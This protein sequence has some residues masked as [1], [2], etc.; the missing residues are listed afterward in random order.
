MKVLLFT[1][2]DSLGP[3]SRIRCLQ[4]ISRLDEHEVKVDAHCL[5]NNKMLLRKFQGDKKYRFGSLLFSYMRRLNQVRRAHLYDVVWIQKEFLPG[6]PFWLEH[7]FL[8]RA[9][10]IALDI[11]DA[12]YLKY[13]KNSNPIKRALYSDKFPKIA[14]NYNLVVV[15]NSFLK[16][17]FTRWS[18]NSLLKVIPSVVDFQKYENNRIYQSRPDNL[19]VIGWIGSPSSEKYLRVIISVVKELAYTSNS[20]VE[21]RLIGASPNQ[22]REHDFITVIPWKECTEIKELSHFDVGIMPL[23]NSEWEEG[24]CSFKV[25]QYMA[26]GKPVVLNSTAANR[27]VIIDG[28]NGLFADSHIAWLN[29][30]KKLMDNPSLRHKMGLANMKRAKR[31]YSLSSQSGVIAELFKSV[32]KGR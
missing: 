18:E 29:S 17:K 15:G 19:F 20:R 32:A 5:I 24:K 7:L 21:L 1:K 31:Y 6:L 12:E 13:Q 14:Q 16:S 30:L 27:E 4:Y 10:K 2:Y 8:K 11:D 22:Y 26:A 23:N 9:K 28:T 25:I 3:S